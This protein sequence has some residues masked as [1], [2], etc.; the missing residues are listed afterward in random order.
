MTCNHAILLWHWFHD[1][2]ETMAFSYYHFYLNFLCVFVH[3]L[4]CIEK[5]LKIFFKKKNYKIINISSAKIKAIKLAKLLGFWIV[6]CT[7]RQQPSM[8]TSFVRCIRSNLIAK[9]A[10]QT[11]FTVM[12]MN[13]ASFHYDKNAWSIGLYDNLNP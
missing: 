3:S 11:N 1:A 8:V 10:T 9:V 7:N 13:L 6:T 4:H 12:Y 2:N 5:I